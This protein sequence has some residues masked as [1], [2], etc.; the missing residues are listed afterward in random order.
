MPCAKCELIAKRSSQ[1]TTLI[2][3]LETENR[4]LAEENEALRLELATVLSADALLP[5]SVLTEVRHGAA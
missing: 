3:R 5:D 2:G 4:R 1:K